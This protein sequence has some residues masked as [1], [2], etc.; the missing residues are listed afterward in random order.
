[1]EHLDRQREEAMEILILV[2]RA[3]L[4]AQLEDMG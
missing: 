2:S 4:D 3:N 1:M